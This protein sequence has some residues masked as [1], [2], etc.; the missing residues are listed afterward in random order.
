M[1]H[2]CGASCAPSH[3]WDVVCAAAAECLTVLL[4]CV[5][6]YL[7]PL[8]MTGYT[9][10]SQNYYAI[11]VAPPSPTSHTGGACA[12]RMCGGSVSVSVVCARCGLCLV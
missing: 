7:P 5:A 8:L 10:S 11:Y 2:A 9:M 6:F 3:V 4:H 1:P 12:R